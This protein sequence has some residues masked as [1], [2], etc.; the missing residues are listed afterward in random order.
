MI[1]IVKGNYGKA[2]ICDNMDPKYGMPALKDKS[3][4]LCLTDYPFNVHYE[5]KGI[6]GT[7][8][9]DAMQ[10][11]Q[12][13]T[14]CQQTYAE[15][16]RISAGQLI[17]CGNSNLV[18]WIKHIAEPINLAIHYKPN[19]N[20][21]RASGYSFALHDSILIYGKAHLQKSVYKQNVEIQPIKDHPCPNNPNLYKQLLLDA[22][23][24]SVIDPFLGSGTT[25]LVCEELGIPWLGY[26]INPAYIKDIQ[27]RIQN[28][29]TLRANQQLAN[30]GEY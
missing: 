2:Y 19:M 23:A 6:E 29:I 15:I 4:D 24:V 17:F 12:Y 13:R 9:D 11:A 25:A 18:M 28:G 22:K 26:E 20:K 8:Y 3:W 27:S 10:S 7:F 16:S 1:E 21:S 5:G 14:F 30:L